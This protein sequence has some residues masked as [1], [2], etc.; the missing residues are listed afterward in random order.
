M[1]ATVER[2][3]NGLIIVIAD[4]A[5]S[6]PPMSGPFVAELTR[7]LQGR[8]SSLALP[9]TWIEQS[10]S[11]TGLTI[12]QLVHAENQQQATDQVSVS[13]SI[14]SLRFLGTM[15]WR[16]FVERVSLVEQTLLEDPCGVYAKQD[17]ATRDCYRHTIETLA[18]Q[19]PLSEH[20]IARKAVELAR[21]E[22][23]EHPT[24]S[25]SSHVGFYIIDA[26]R[27][28]LESAVGATLAFIERIRRACRRAPLAVFIGAIAAGT[29]A[30]AA[31]LT[32]QA[33]VQGSAPAMI[34]VFALLSLLAGSQ[35]AVS[36][37]NLFATVLTTPQLLPRMDYAKGVPAHSRTLVVVPTLLRSVE[38][39][40]AL[41][42]A[43]EVRFLAN[44]DENIY[45]GLLTDFGDAYEEMRPEDAALLALARSRI[46]A[47]NEKHGGTQ[48]S[49]FFLFQ[50]PRRWAAHD[51]IWMGRER[52][53]GKLEDLN[54]LLRVGDEAAFSL[55]IGDTRLLGTVRYVI[56]LDTDT[57][58]PLDS[59][60]HLIEVMAHPLN[61]A[62]YDEH[63]Q[64]VT[65]G[66]GILQPRVGTS[67]T[68]TG[69]SRYVRLWS[70]EPGID[71]YTR[72]VS[73]VY[74]DLFGE[75]SFIGKG[76]YDVDAFQQALDG[77]LPD[78]RILSHDLLEGSYA[79][80]G[81]VSDVELFERFPLSYSADAARRHRWT[82]GD[83]QIASWVLPRV[84]HPGQGSQ[85]N[86]LSA[87]S[88]WKIFDNV[89]RSLTPF[90]LMALLWLAWFTLSPAW[91]WTLAVIGV[92]FASPV[93]ASLIELFRRPDETSLQQHVS[94]ILSAG[95]RH[96]AQAVY[97][98]AC[99]PYEAWYNLD[100]AVRS[101]ARILTQRRLLE[102]TTASEAESTSRTGLPAYYSTMW[103]APTAAIAAA[104]SVWEIN[105]AAL[106]SAAP[107]LLLWLTAPAIAWWVSMPSSRRDAQLAADDIVFLRKTARKT[108]AFFEDFV[109]AEDNHLPPD[110]YQEH[111]A[112]VLAH[113]TS[114][115]NMGLSLLAN[116]TA[117]DF[118]YI[119][120]GPLL[121]RTEFAFASL[122]RLERFHG[123]FY[124]WY[125]THTFR[126]LAPH[127]VS[128]VD[129][130]N[131]SGYLMILRA[132]L[133]KLPEERIF[134]P[135]LFEGIADA[136]ELLR[137]DASA[138]AGTRI[139][140]AQTQL[141]NLRAQSPATLSDA[142]ES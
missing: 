108:W 48:R 82:R 33:Y 102:W 62:H 141:A 20:D 49:A 125:D 117:Y 139:T 56:T 98:L 5:R 79:R 96:L 84:P 105:P 106:Y 26:G 59:A 99:L 34:V 114:P 66:Y 111:P 77:V 129:S 68:E 115:T 81:L 42:E 136:F 58:L 18:K 128:S 83:W 130:G 45:F 46:E 29:V 110:N 6:N 10:L 89:R 11:D 118:G 64:R 80:A 86:P 14:G 44:R 72:A 27:E 2:D 40:D 85:R 67:L 23:T 104:I 54:R 92:V 61:R 50:R 37:V 142:Y 7:R 16:G 30:F 38:G 95:S 47:L 107:V 12:E 132:A 76:I 63:Q 134:H 52:K 19:S 39:V 138:L 28:Q 94:S 123:H 3:P 21:A 121:R 70:G 116:V 35:L 87:L 24:E 31:F 74:Q 17:F 103:S 36:L 137:D 15:D 75:G 93:I 122:Q 126:P 22:H 4:M 109:A 73:D 97:T 124:N 131:L 55:I 69:G 43:L 112:R 140:H 78:N 119:A 113:R 13:N 135:Q 25:L 65:R 88:R 91:F 9:L 57:Q 1:L 90:A 60:R 100:A 71:P 41:T 32:T 53:R 51:K 101:T 8:S 120:T 133:L 127:Y